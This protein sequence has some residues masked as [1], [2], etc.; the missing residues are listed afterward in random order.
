M[1]QRIAE[2][3]TIASPADL[4]AAINHAEKVEM[5]RSFAASGQQGPKQGTPN[6]G[7][8]GFYCGRG[9]FNA[10]QST[11]TANPGTQTDSAQCAAQQSFNP[12][13]R[14]IGRNQCSRCR[15]WGH[16]AKDCPSP[17]NA[18]NRGGRGRYT[19]GRR[20]GRGGRRG[21]G[22]G[23][24]NPSVNAALQVSDAGAPGPSTQQVQ[25]AVPVPSR[26]Q[27]N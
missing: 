8:G 25:G 6:R 3:V 26:Q 18:G 2:L 4:H 9:K 23:S 15:G 5:A 21:G 11:G 17:Y 7:R 24:G 13:Q 22:S 16:W 14:P 19:R 27:G 12:T 20:G 10:V 1:H